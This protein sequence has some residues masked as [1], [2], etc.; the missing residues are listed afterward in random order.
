MI[1]TTPSPL[2]RGLAIDIARCRPA[3]ELRSE[4]E[5]GDVVAKHERA[6]RELVERRAVVELSARDGLDALGMELHVDRI[7]ADL[8]GMELSQRLPKST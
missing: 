6:I 5:P 1:S 2:G 4:D 3:H 8:T 7:R